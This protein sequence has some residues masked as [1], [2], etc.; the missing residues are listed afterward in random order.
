MSFEKSRR[1]SRPILDPISL[2]QQ[3]LLSNDGNVRPNID[4]LLHDN[5]WVVT[6]HTF[7][8][9]INRV[10][11]AC[12]P[13]HKFHD[14]PADIPDNDA[15][16][17]CYQSESAQSRGPEHIY[18][19]FDEHPQHVDADFPPPRFAVKR[20]VPTKIR[21]GGL[22]LFVMPGMHVPTEVC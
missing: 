21:D 19:M 11:P 14:D 6:K 9:T 20:Y 3:S 16:H 12:W 8:G 1:Y 13:S 7:L 10:N 15:L 17:I 2:P 22:T 5:S 4:S 18:Q